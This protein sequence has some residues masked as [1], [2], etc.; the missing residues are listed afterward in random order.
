M[1]ELTK[2]L[3]NEYIVGTA[4]AVIIFVLTFLLKLPI[5]ALTRK[6]SK[7]EHSRKIKN[8]SIVFIPFALGLLAEF[9]YYY[10]YLQDTFIVVRGIGYGSAAIALYAPVAQFFK[11]K[12]GIKLENPFDTEEAK[13]AQ[14]LMSNVQKDG[15]IDKSDVS[16]VDEFWKKINK[17]K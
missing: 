9:L 1:E 16:A 13:A 8:L 3:S 4:M 10:L 11:E 2:L 7:T 14:E 5:K 17:G 6:Y 15:K 12:T